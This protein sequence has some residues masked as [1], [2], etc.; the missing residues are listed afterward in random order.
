MTARGLS[1]RSALAAGLAL[2]ELGCSRKEDVIVKTGADK[3]LTPAQIDEDPVPLLPGGAIGVVYIDARAL[4]GSKFGDKLLTVVQRRTP[5]PPS[6]GFDPRRDLEKI[7]LGFYSMQGADAAGVVV[8]TFDPKKIEAAADGVQ[9][10]PLGVPVTKT[11]YAG[12]ALYTAGSLGFSILTPRTAFIGNDTG[13]RR[14]LDRIE[15]G[16]ARRQLPPYMDKLLAASNAPLV[17]GADFTSSPLPD[18]ARQE[19]AFL[20]GVKTLAV[21]GNFEEPGLNLAGTLSYADEAAAQ[22]G[23]QNLVSMRSSL[24]RYA[25]FLALLGIAQPIQKL[26]VR[27]QGTELEFVIGVDGTAV[28]ALLEKAQDLLGK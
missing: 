11:T 3:K 23:A 28:A 27:P 18:A 24:E 17:G 6:A 7:W 21:V 8:G 22:R 20:D 2:L 26:E 10:T 14:A 13:M 12:R 15:E 25:P 16:R 9:K 19:L 1:R 5:L 4:F